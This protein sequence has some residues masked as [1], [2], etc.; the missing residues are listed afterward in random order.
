MWEV[1]AKLRALAIV[2]V[3]CLMSMGKADVVL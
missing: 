2:F 3:I 1:H